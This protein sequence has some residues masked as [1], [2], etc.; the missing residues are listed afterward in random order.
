[1]RP[2]YHII[3][4]EDDN[5]IRALLSWIVVRVY[6]TVAI[7]TVNTGG[8]ALIVY[9]Q[10]GADL[11]ITSYAMAPMNGLD[12]VRTLRAHQVTIPIVMSSGDVA[13]EQPALSCG[14]TRFVAKPFGVTRF[15]EVLASLLPRES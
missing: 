14:V 6:E 15:A 4:A 12:L 2:A 13:I 1:M 8:D 5:S 10:R 3:I 11:L 7:S 9:G